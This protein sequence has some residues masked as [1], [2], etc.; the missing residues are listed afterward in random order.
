MT[1]PTSTCSRVTTNVDAVALRLAIASVAS[2]RDVHPQ[3]LAALMPSFPALA[4]RRWAPWRSKQLLDT[5]LPESF[6]DVLASVA[7]FTDPF[8]D[9][10][11]AQ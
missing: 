3:S 8:L 7:R 2:H 4:Q 11:R 10:E 9:G 1:S 5:V 6:A